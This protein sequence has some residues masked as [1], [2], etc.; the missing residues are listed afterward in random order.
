MRKEIK[1]WRRL[2]SATCLLLIVCSLN[3]W[4][5]CKPEIQQVPVA[6]GETKIVGKIVNGAVTFEP[7]ENPAGDYFIITKALWWT[8]YKLAQKV[9][10]LELEIKKLE[11]KGE[12]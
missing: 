1:P 4:T 10:L 2:G 11:A 8:T 7:G 6:I 3:F 9:R 12:K 5:S